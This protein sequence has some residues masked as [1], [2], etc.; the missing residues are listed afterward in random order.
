MNSITFSNSTA[1]KSI[2]VEKRRSFIFTQNE[3][4]SKIIGYNYASF[5][6]CEILSE[7]QYIAGNDPLLLI[8]ELS[9]S[10]MNCNSHDD[11]HSLYEA[12]GL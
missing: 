3:N 8:L 11:S 1:F 2:L 4:S 6:R 7:L 10:V 5:R 9:E 12:L